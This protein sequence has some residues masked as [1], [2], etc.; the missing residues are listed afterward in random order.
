MH[1]SPILAG[2]LAGCFAFWF[3][4]SAPA[5]AAW[6]HS[7]ASGVN[8]TNWLKDQ[9]NSVVCS[10]GAGGAFVAWSDQRAIADDSDVFMQR[11]DQAGRPQWAAGGVQ[12]CAKAN[13]QFAIAVVSDMQG[14][15]IIVWMDQRSFATTCADLYAG[16]VDVAGCRRHMMLGS[17]TGG[18]ASKESHLPPN[19]GAGHDANYCEWRVTAQRRAKSPGVRLAGCR[20]SG[21]ACPTSHEDPS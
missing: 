10:D 2:L 15:A 12:V 9:R 6:P 21:L 1:L 13:G 3:S 20:Y 19:A 7:P 17:L 14:G 11:L 8:V 5:F 18:L 4:A 16:R